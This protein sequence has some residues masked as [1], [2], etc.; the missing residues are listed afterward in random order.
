[1]AREGGAERAAER[2][3]GEK[4][5][6]HDAEGVDAAAHHVRQHAGPEHFL[7]KCDRAGK[8]HQRQYPARS[9]KLP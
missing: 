6:H 7:E 3:A 8:Q 5:R 1:M 9:R 2:N 4:T